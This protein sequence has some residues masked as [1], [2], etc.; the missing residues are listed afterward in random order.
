MTIQKENRRRRSAFA[1]V[2]ACAL[3][4]ALLPLQGCGSGNGDTA[5]PVA[6]TM[7][8]DL[9]EK[10]ISTDLRLVA[11][12]NEEMAVN[13]Q[14][15]RITIQ[16]PDPASNL[17]IICYPGVQNLNEAMYKISVEYGVE[18]SQNFIKDPVKGIQTIMGQATMEI[19]TS[20]DLGEDNYQQTLY[21]IC[22]NQTFYLI[23]TTCKK[24]SADADLLGAMVA[25]ISILE[26]SNVNRDAMTCVYTDPY[27]DVTASTRYPKKPI[28]EWASLPSS[29]YGAWYNGSLYR[30]NPMHLYD[31]GCLTAAGYTYPDESKYWSWGW[32]EGIGFN[33]FTDHTVLYQLYALNEVK[34]KEKADA[35]AKAAA[36]AAA[37]AVAAQPDYSGWSDPGDYGYDYYDDPY[38][39]DEPQAWSDP[40][41]YGYSDWSDP[42]DYGYYY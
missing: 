14:S 35:D 27:P 28:T 6:N 39:Y 15:G 33:F 21:G 10:Y 29:G 4:A 11:L 18:N 1:A 41:D 30:D 8:T 17:A 22:K 40:G 2:V 12:V 23:K 32:D 34:A 9:D 36:E 38:Y 3:C 7:N 19:N 37:A 25:K 24:D 5:A 16:F 31:V 13:D 20:Y 26:P 42:G